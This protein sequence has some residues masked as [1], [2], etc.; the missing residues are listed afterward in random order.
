MQACNI[1]FS[2]GQLALDRKAACTPLSFK[3]HLCVIADAF[4]CDAFV[5]LRAEILALAASERTC[6]PTHKKGAT[7]GYD[8]LRKHA[9]AVTALYHDPAFQDFIAGIV[10]ADIGP[11]PLRDNS[12]LS[13]LVYDRPGDHIGWHYDHNFYRGR[14]FTI[15]VGIENANHDRSAL[16]G[17]KLLVK[18]RTGEE[19]EIPTPPNTLVLFEGARTLHKVTPILEREHRV[20]LSMTYCTDPRN[21][22][23]QEITRRVKDTAFF[24]LRALWD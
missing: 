13:I 23:A 12:S 9:P 14:H 8:I 4:P 5:S 6:V 7:I 24:G 22:R 10:G 19:V 15:L 16:S 18:R 17:A 1:P 3:D 20:M 2:A 21:T 11:T